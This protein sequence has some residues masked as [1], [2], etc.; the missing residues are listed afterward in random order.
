MNFDADRVYQVLDFI[1]AKQNLQD[2]VDLAAPA[3]QS[4]VKKKWERLLWNGSI[5]ELGRSIKETVTGKDKRKKALKKFSGYFFANR[6]RMQYASFKKFGLPR[7]SGHVES[8]IRRVI[9]LRLK[10]PGT[11]WLKDMAECFLFLRSQ[12]LSGRW[13]IFM[14]N[15]T[16]LV[17]RVF[18]PVYTNNRDVWNLPEAA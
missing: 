16:A 15:L 5:D 4:A 1:H 17:R 2:I 6:K 14:G 10:A 7:G 9:N 18:W 8:A 3:K 12:L 11:F 13:E